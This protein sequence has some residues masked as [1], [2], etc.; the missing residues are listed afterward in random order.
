MQAIHTILTQ[1]TAVT[2]LLASGTDSVMHL[3]ETHGAP[4]PYICIDSEGDA[5]GSFE[6]TVTE[7]EVNLTITI[8]ADWQYTKGSNVGAWQVGQAVK[9]ALEAASGTYGSEQ[10]KRIS[11][12]GYNFQNYPNASRDKVLL[13]QEYQVF[14]KR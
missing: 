2:S 6:A 1:A 8:I 11:Y 7:E 4:N 3:M 10:I 12:Q 13:E 14:V 9:A 5:I